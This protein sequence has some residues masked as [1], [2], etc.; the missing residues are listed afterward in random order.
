MKTALY[1]LLL[2]VFMFN[3]GIFVY[4][5]LQHGGLVIQWVAAAANGVTALLILCRILLLQRQK[6]PPSRD[7]K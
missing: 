6:P 7:L 3:T 5:A 4:L 1:F 2:V